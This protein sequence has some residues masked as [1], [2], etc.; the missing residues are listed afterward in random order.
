[1]KAGKIILYVFF[2]RQTYQCKPGCLKCYNE[3]FCSICDTE[4]DM[5][6]LNN[7]CIVIKFDHC[8]KMLS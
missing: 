2:F 3:T 8:L 1:M 4:Q 7:E 5:F 6:L